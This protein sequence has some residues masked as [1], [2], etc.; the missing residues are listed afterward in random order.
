MSIESQPGNFE[1][2]FAD[3]FFPSSSDEECDDKEN[4]EP[5]LPTMVDV[6][7]KSDPVKAFLDEEAEEEDDSDND[8]MRFQ[9]NEEDEENEENEDLD[10]LIA[11]GYKEM[12]ID[13]EKRD[14][15]HQKWLEQQDAAATENVLQRLKCGQKQ[16]ELTLL[17]E[18]E[19]DEFSQHSMDEPMDDLHPTHVAK[20]N[21]RK[22]KQMIAQMYTD[23]DDVF[24][25]SDDEETEKRLVR[26]RLLEQ[27][28]SAF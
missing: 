20:N 16:T 22:V 11:T 7:P 19:D 12:P 25:S 23:K 4:T 10:D 8:L 13:S 15:L 6:H 1:F 17:Q 18:E 21:S 2:V 24:L 26:H 3:F 27:T 14:E 5:R 9:Q 28:V